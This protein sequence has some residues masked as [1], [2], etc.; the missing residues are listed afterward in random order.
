MASVPFSCVAPM[1]S[2]KG[3]HLILFNLFLIIQFLPGSTILV[4]SS[5][6]HHGDVTIQANKTRQSFTQ[7]CPGGLLCWVAYGV[8]CVHE[9]PADLKYHFDEMHNQ[10]HL[11]AIGLFSSCKSCTMIWWIW[12]HSRLFSYKLG[13]NINPWV[14]LCY[15]GHSGYP[16]LLSHCSLS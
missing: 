4:P 10:C 16:L 14:R 13:V 8:Q 1:I 15:I 7:Y 11:T 9:S 5:T 3:R 2:P 6:I 12:F